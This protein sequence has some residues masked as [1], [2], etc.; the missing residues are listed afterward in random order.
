MLNKRILVLVSLLLI[1]FLLVGCGL[2]T[3][4][5]IINQAPVIT[6]YPVKTATVGVE[7]TY[8]VDA[9]DDDTLTYSLVTKPDGM[10]IN[11]A[12]GLIKWIPITSQFGD[13][14]V[15]VEVSDRVLYATQTFTILVTKRIPMTI[16]VDLPT[17]FTVGESTWFTVYMTANSDVGKSVVASFSGD[18]EILED[19]E[20]EDGSGLIF[21]G[22][23][24]IL[25]ENATAHFR[26]TFEEAGT[27][28]TTLKVKTT[29]GKTLCSRSFTIVV[30]P[31]LL[32]YIVVDPKI[33]TLINTDFGG[34]QPFTVTAHY[35]NG[36]KKEIGFTYYSYDE[37][38]TGIVSVWPALEVG[39]V[40][41]INAGTVTIT[42]SYTEGVITKTDEIEVTV[43][44]SS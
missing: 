2:I 1:S 9:T 14:T 20:I 40:T 44:T 25:P 12:T 4:P 29:S 36:T 16:T 19:L 10:T 24:F 27:F 6:S 35:N 38:P 23:V 18:T 26:G 34:S 11:P 5:V 31:A 17:T 43:N 33:M 21:E 28:T 37:N 30:E 41:A 8:D 22:D 39:W 13:N 7:Y 3:P 15:K 32:D 42:V